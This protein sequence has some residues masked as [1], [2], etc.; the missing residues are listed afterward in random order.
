MP[1]GSGASKGRRSSRLSQNLKKSG[2]QVQINKHVCCMYVCL[3][4]VD[5]MNIAFFLS[6]SL[7]QV[8]DE[9]TRAMVRQSR[10]ESYE[11]DNAT[12][13]QVSIYYK[14]IYI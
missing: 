12:D 8:V 1:R 10:I 5:H 13:P 4:Y 3:Y 11:D 2:Y 9:H 6:L 7:S 14:S